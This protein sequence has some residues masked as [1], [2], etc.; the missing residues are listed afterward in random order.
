MCGTRWIRLYV[1]VCILVVAGDAVQGGESWLQ[2]KFDARHSGNVPNRDV[3][4]PLGLIGAVPLSDAIFTAPV[5]VDGS[6]YVVD[7]SGVVYCISSRTLKLRW[8]TTTRGGRAN[9]NNVSS[10]VVLGPYLHFGTMSGSYYVLNRND[11]SVVRE[12]RTGD[13]IFSTPVVANGRAYF[14]TLGARV[15][16]VEPNGD[17]DWTWDFVKEVIGF[18][19][20]RWSGSDWQQFKKGRVTWRDHFCCSRNLA[21]FGSTI[22]VPAG[23]RTVFL[24]DTGQAARLKLVGLIPKYAGREYPAAFGQS[25]GE[26]GEVYVQWHR[27]DNAGRVEVLKLTDDRTLA[28]DFVPG[29]QTAINLHGLLSFSSVSLRGRDVYRCRPEA[30]FGFCRHTPDKEQPQPLGGFP[31]IAAPVLLRRHG[32]SGGLDGRLYVVPLEG[33]GDVWSYKTAFGNAISAPVAVCDGRIYFGCEDGYLYVL[34]SEGR[35]PQPTKQLELTTIRSPLSGRFAG[36]KY[37]WFTNYGNAA[38]TNWNDQHIRPPLAMK[39]IRRY[40]GTFKH[41]P[42][43]GGG[44]MYTHTAEGQVF[45]VEQETGRLLWRRYWPGV[46]LSFTSPVYVRRGNRE[47]LLVPQAG[48]KQ[49]WLRCLD[50]VTGLLVWQ[51]GFTGS[52]SWSRQAPPIIYKGLAIYASGSGNYAA[53]GTEKPFIFRGQPKS[54]PNGAEVMSWIY[55]HNNPYYPKNNK[56]LIWAWDLATGKLVWKNDFSS[57]GRG[58]NDC[59]LCLLDGMLYYSTFFG[60]SSSKRRRGLPTAHN[61]LTAALNPDDGKVRWLTTKYFVTAGCTISAKD[62]RLYLGGYNR[63]NESTQDRFVYCLDARNGSLLWRSDPVRSAVNVITVGDRFVFSNAYG[64]DAHLFNRTT[65][66]T[67]SRFDQGYA[68]TRFTVSGSFLMGANMDMIDLAHGNRLVSTGPSIDSRECV[69]ATISNGRMFYTSQA[70]GLQASQ[71]AADEA[72]AQTSPWTRD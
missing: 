54:T 59:G 55:T 38:Q 49:S 35:A 4:T 43:C 36:A 56:P 60:Y 46:Y 53:Q 32:V 16:C 41:L 22:V 34:G 66:K 48:I 31:S 71:V 57:Y 5:V 62:G 29:T 61:G 7:G 45:A 69:G 44:R 65:G 64:R 51:A 8:K 9:C 33:Q 6:I 26:H 67:I 72:A 30:G 13:P 2:F 42:V 50:A 47:L 52:P 10:P 37:D 58:G 12:L 70:S 25:I 68:C 15:F 11:G 21:A 20:D 18:E 40:E 39:W 3:R 27:R 17:V 24:E 28:T 14:A 1:C 23:G 63:P 19:G